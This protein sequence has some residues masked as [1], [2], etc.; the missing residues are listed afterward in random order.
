MSNPGPREVKEPSPPNKKPGGKTLTKTGKKLKEKAQSKKNKASNNMQTFDFTK[1]NMF[2]LKGLRKD[3]A[4]AFSEGI[5][6]VLIKYPILQ[7]YF[8][9]AYDPKRFHI[10][11]KVERPKTT[12]ALTSRDTIYIMPK[13]LNKSPN[14]SVKN[15]AIHEMGHVLSNFISDTGFK[16]NKKDYTTILTTLDKIIN[17]KPSV[18]KS[19]T[20]KYGTN[21]N[22]EYF[23][24]AFTGIVNGTADTSNEYIKTFSSWL[25]D[26]EG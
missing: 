14:E 2:S 22:N 19:L 26:I 10:P 17:K 4:E 16:R 1:L 15:T 20:H 21:N 13:V 11:V 12:S 5:A 8:A 23:A 24:R 18:V 3:K 9:G 6:K 7:K 25:K